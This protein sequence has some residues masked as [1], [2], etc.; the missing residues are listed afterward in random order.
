MDKNF[1]GRKEELQMLK[2]I[3]SS[4]RAEFVAVY[5]R[6]RVGKTYLIQQFFNNDFAFSATGIIEGSK[7]SYLP[8][9]HPSSAMAIKAHSQRHGLKPLNV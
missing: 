7:R 6:R 3:K 2:D 9:L 4:G 8:L 1:I 5:G